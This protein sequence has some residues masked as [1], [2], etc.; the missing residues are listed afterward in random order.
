M[1]DN[2][3]WKTTTRKI[4]A[5]HNSKESWKNNSGWEVNG[6]KSCTARKKKDGKTLRLNAHPRLQRVA[7]LLPLVSLLR[8]KGCEHLSSSPTFSTLPSLIVKHIKRLPASYFRHSSAI[9]CRK[10]YEKIYI[11]H[12]SKS[13]IVKK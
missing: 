7:K 12:I 8:A 2:T 5:K 1:K 6:T 9:S 10:A 4:T 3:E 11:F 13:P